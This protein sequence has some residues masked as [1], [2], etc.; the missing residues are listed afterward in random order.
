MRLCSPHQRMGW[1]HCLNDWWGGQRARPLA[2]RSY[3]LCGV[4]NV[5][6]LLVGPGLRNSERPHPCFIFFP[7]PLFAPISPSHESILSINHS[8]IPIS[9]S[10]SKKP[11]LRFLLRE[12]F[13]IT[14]PKGEPHPPPFFS[15]SLPSFISALTHIILKFSFFLYT[16]LHFINFY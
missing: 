4:I 5:L 7:C 8:G 3:Q 12:A 1:S 16:F 6:E 11:Y 15:V 9:G 10:A 14:R 13:L 2:I